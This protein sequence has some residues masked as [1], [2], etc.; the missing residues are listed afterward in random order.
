VAINAVL[1]GKGTT[2]TSPLTTASGTTSA[3]G[4]TFV[5]LVSFDATVTASTPTDSKSNTYVQ[6]ATTLTT[7]HGDKVAVYVCENGTGG[8]SH[9][10]SQTFSGSAAAAGYLIEVT[11]ATTTPTDIALTGTDASS[12]FTIA[13]GTLAQANEAVLTICACNQTVSSTNTYSSSNT[14]ILSQESNGASFWTSAVSLLVTSATTSVSPSFTDTQG[15]AAGLIIV[16]FKEAAGGG[17]GAALTGQSSTST[18][19]TVTPSVTVGLTGQSATFTAGSVGAQ[20][21]LVGRPQVSGPGISPDYRQMFRG[22]MLSS[23]APAN[24]TVGLTGQSSTFSPGSI[25][26]SSS[27]AI[28]G[29]SISS[30]VGSVLAASQIVVTGQ[31]STTAAGAIV[32]S[33]QR[34]LTGQGSTFSSGAVVPGL[35]V[36]LV[37][38]AATFASGT[39]ALGSTVVLT[40]QSASFTAGNLVA[41]GGGNVTLALT[42][43]SSSFTAGALLPSSAAALTGQAITSTTGGIAP[44]RTLAFTGQSATFA[45]GNLLPSSAVGVAGQ[46]ATFTAGNVTAPNGVTL[47]LTGQAASFTSGSITPS[48]TVG[49][50]GQSITSSAGTLATANAHAL[51]GS[52]ITSSSGTL[53]GS[54]TVA[55]TGQQATFTSGLVLPPSDKTASLT[56]SSATFHTGTVLGI[57]AVLSGTPRYVVRRVMKRTFTVSAVSYSQFPP[58]DT[59]EAVKLEFDFAPDLDSGVLLTGT[60]TVTVTVAGAD[61]TPTAILNGLPRFDVTSTQVIVPVVGGVA[62]CDYDVKVVVPTTD[63][64]TVLALSGILPVRA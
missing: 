54:F 63:S 22:R 59:S 20:I 35:Q 30:S 29:A 21:P 62:N 56:G 39:L 44:A 27:V 12:P 61:P 6:K 3:S 48:A 2:A 53:L 64:L 55:L 43:Q 7:G 51:A 52:A 4:S 14:T 8:A 1:V 36:T 16:S 13:S 42:G 11:G 37:G 9:T 26:P 23:A 45:A 31:S 41:S 46:S 38:Q 57:G 10:V 60:P 24:V 34:A 18:A 17:A 19:G 15:T 40:G 58:K 47:A 33:A 25:G 49:L 28:T 5:Y 50:T 32:P